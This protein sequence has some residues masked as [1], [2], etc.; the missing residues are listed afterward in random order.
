MNAARRGVVLL[1]VLIV[2][3]AL[4]LAAYA[5]SELM[6]G[7]NQTTHLSGQQ[8]QAESLAASGVEAVR[9]Y[10]MLPS[11]ARTA[12]GGQYDNAG[13]FRARTVVGQDDPGERGNF[14][15]LAP[16]LDDEGNPAGVRYGLEDESAR[17][18]L[19]ALV[20][21]ETKVQQGGQQQGG[22]QQGGQQQG[23]TSS[24]SVSAATVDPNS[25]RTLL[26][27]LPGMTEDVADAILDW[28]DEGDDPREYGAESD[29]YASLN[30]PYACKNRPL[31]T[32]EELLLVRGVTPE[33]LFGQDVNRNGLIDAAEMAGSSGTATNDT[34]SSTSSASADA[35]LPQG[36]WAPFLTLFSKEQNVNAN[37]APRI[38]LNESDLR[39]L[40]DNLSAVFQPDWVTFI[41]AY[42]QNGEYTTGNEAGE[43]GVQGELDLAQPSKVTFN[44]VLDLIGKRVKVT[45]KGAKDPTILRSPFD[46]DVAAM[47]LYMPSLMDQ[48]TAQD[49]EILGRININQA[50]RQILLGIPGMTEDIVDQ[51][52]RVRQPEPDADHPQRRYETWLLTEAIV[53]LDE[54]RTMM[55]F[56]CAGG[57]VH[58]AQVVGYFERGHPAARIE[59]VLDS[60]QQPARILLWRDISHL[61]RGFALEMLGVGLEEG[62]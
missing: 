53:K 24:P 20:E 17:I 14:T 13:R 57:A 35:S 15:V 37:G 28:I 62:L 3:A 16:A 61:G 5:F 6:L 32:V 54:M 49:G 33:L 59:A 7:Y 58:R 48:V 31:E 60:T 46:N 26:M 42:R 45:F 11:D 47:N 8:V 36:G 52:L 29:Y 27:A 25:G 41:I 43:K 12:A 23:G 51:I 30:P 21:M 38:N 34:S 19:N 1:I 44:Q 18:N 10:L 40:S 55:P 2:V 22:Q 4:A 50:P 56:V 9:S 39:T